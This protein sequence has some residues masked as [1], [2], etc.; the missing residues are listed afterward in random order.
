MRRGL[1]RGG[2]AETQLSL[3]INLITAV[4]NWM[5]AL[6]LWQRCFVPR[7]FFHSYR[8]QRMTRRPAFVWS[9]NASHGVAAARTGEKRSM[10]QRLAKSLTTTCGPRQR[11]AHHFQSYVCWSAASSVYSQYVLRAPRLQMF[12]NVHWLSCAHISSSL[13]ASDA[14]D[15][16][17]RRSRCDK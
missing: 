14:M 10:W 7:W 5:S 9:H 2:L 4:G 16:L 11:F 15:N 17:L 13:R 3:Q 1:H 6:T 8:Q 12:S